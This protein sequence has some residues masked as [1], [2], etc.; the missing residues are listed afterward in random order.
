MYLAFAIILH[1]GSLFTHNWHEVLV[2]YHAAF[3]RMVKYLLVKE[4]VV[5]IVVLLSSII[6]SMGS[7][8]WGFA[9]EGYVVLSHW[10]L[11]F[12]AI[13]LL[14]QWRGWRWVSTVGLFIAILLAVI[15]VWFGFTP[16][17]MI[18]GVSFA[19]FAWDM[20]E[21]RARFHFILGDDEIRG[22]E[23]RHIARITFIILA[24]L[25]LVTVIL[26]FRSQF[27][28]E[29]G[30]FFVLVILLSFW[31]LIAWIRK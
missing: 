18:S 12:G 19:L 31:Q 27:R 3:F 28:L 20:T 2:V 24:E 29:W 5:T 17:W 1:G 10:M 11:A 4:I 6:L 8:A 15:G 25:F 26:L 21:F 14:T 13:W 9:E 22:M 7:L 30:A 16:S 23:R